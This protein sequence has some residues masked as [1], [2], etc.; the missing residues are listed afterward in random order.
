MRL[1]ISAVLFAIAAVIGIPLSA[2]ANTLYFPQVAFGG[3]YSTTFTL[4][5]TG[6]TSV[7]STLTFYDQNG[8]V[9]TALNKPV[10]LAAGS[11]TRVNLPNQGSA[12]TVVWGELVAGAG[13][14]QGVATFEQRNGTQLQTVAGV[15][16]IDAGDSFLLPVDVSADGSTNTGVALANNSTSL[17]S[18]RLRLIGENGSQ[19]S[20]NTATFGSFAAR[21]QAADFVTSWFPQISGQPFRGTL[22]VETVSGP[23][24]ALVAT[25]LTAKE[26][27]LS[28]LAVIPSTNLGTAGRALYFPQVAFGGGYST[29]FRVSESSAWPLW[30]DAH[31]LCRAFQQHS[32]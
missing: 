12:I 18:V 5:N 4:T 13:T 11:S 24:G 17:I 30:R 25:A 2:L 6:T 16:G 9:Q 14:V 7:S 1:R 29:T 3:G 23:T 32:E 28:A 26:G 31:R 22:V 21:R 8:N 10:T 20:A 27:I 15:L 19:I